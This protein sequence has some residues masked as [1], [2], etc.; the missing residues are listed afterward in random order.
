MSR[1]LLAID[2]ARPVALT[3]EVSG[4][5]A[6]ILGR[7]PVRIAAKLEAGEWKFSVWWVGSVWD[8]VLR[9]WDSFIFVLAIV[10]FRSM[11]WVNFPRRVAGAVVGCD[12]FSMRLSGRKCSAGPTAGKSAGRSAVIPL[13]A[14]CSPPAI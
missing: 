8:F 9:L 12:A 5:V 6:Q 13:A 11:R 14:T 4:H 2:E 3:R 1:R 7:I 10:I